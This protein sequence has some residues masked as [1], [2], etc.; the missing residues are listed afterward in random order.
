MWMLYLSLAK[1]T[2]LREKG[3]EIPEKYIAAISDCT[4]SPWAEAFIQFE[5]FLTLLEAT[6]TFLQKKKK[7]RKKEKRRKERI[8]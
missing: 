2:V 5:S 6:F 7:K 3:R 8:L 1:K 4:L